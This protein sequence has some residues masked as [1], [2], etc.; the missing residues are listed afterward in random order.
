MRARWFLAAAVGLWLAAVAR[1]GF[2]DWITATRMPPL[3]LAT[4]VEVLDREGTLLRAYT[5]GDGR[6]RLEP[7]PVDPLFLKMLVA[8]EDGRFY[9]HP[10]VDARALLR[11]V[12][13]AARSGHVV[14]GGSTLTMQVARLLEA[15]GTGKM[16]GKLRQMRVALALERRL[17]K[18]EI[19]SLY[20]R[21]APYGGNLEGV[22]AASIS[23]LGKEP[24]RLTAAEAALL[25][26]IPQ[27]PEGRRPDRHPDRAET[28]RSRVLAR[29][30][31]AGVIAA[32]RA[33][34]ARSEP[35][36]RGRKPFP[37]L[38]PHLADRVRDADPLLHQHRLTLDASLQR[39]LEDLASETVVG[40]GERLQVAMLVADHRSGEVL[41]S[42]GSAGYR[43]DRRQGFMDMTVALRSP[44]SLLKPLIFGL[45]FDEGL[46]HPATLLDDRPMDFGGYRPQN[47]DRIFRGEIRAR[48]A[49]QLSL[50]L[51]AVAL[52][53]AL[54]PARLL[55][56]LEQAGVRPV[57]PGGQ[58]GLAVALGGVGVTL[59][60]MVQLY[61]ALAREGVVLPLHVRGEGE[62]GRRLL[63]EV[64][65]WQVAD[66][67]S[68]MPPPPGA[69]ANRLAY[70]TG[71]SYGHRDA[72]AIGFDGAHVV[73]VWLGRA[74]GTPVPGVFGADLAAP[75]L[76]RAFARLKPALTPLPP[77]PR[78][79]LTV[80]NAELP[81]PL[82]RFRSR[83]AAFAAEDGPAVAFPPDGAEVERLGGR[84]KVKVEGGSGPFTWLADGAP[85]AIA[86]PGR[87][88]ML[89]LAPGFLTLSVI[90]GDGRSARSSIRVH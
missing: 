52:T 64:S 47:F 50:N 82:R 22:R 74:D 65:A 29:A 56:A 63:S 58:P 60:D 15:S 40:Q 3:S 85:V 9:H 14:S 39:R 67:L 19:L 42:V 5:V 70:K 51:P 78:A 53:D 25:V 49:L 62:T 20:L 17:S 54:G 75:V 71:T 12:W 33:E 30:V 37:A 7:G 90:D 68:G 16:A 87:E 34:A 43:A 77:P 55:S 59:A 72:W 81:Q 41:A 79:A 11:A 35:V 66:I 24:W 10:G 46:A 21:L 84:L 76:F 89:D 73:G 57:L 44:G 38:A 26:A 13:Q 32:E 80:S 69:P 6:W 45:A 36:P 48:E 2:D 8:Y 1:D 27:S 86:L 88:T 83:V 23:Y 28:A 4:S 31:R 18:D 61:A